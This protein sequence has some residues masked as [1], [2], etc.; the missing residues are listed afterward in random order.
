MAP[1]SKTPEGELTAPELRKLIRAHNILS[2]ITIPKGSDREGLIKLIE[3]SG[4]K[5]NHAKKRLDAQVKRGKQITLKK[6]EELTKPK[7]V[8]DAVKKQRAEKKKEQEEQKEKDIKIAKKEAVQE[9]KTKKKEA[10]KLKSIPPRKILKKENLSNTIKESMGETAFIKQQKKL[11]LEKQKETRSALLKQNVKVDKTT[12]RGKPVKKVEPVKKEETGIRLITDGKVDIRV[13]NVE[14]ILDYIDKTFDSKLP[15][16]AQVKKLDKLFT[17]T[18]ENPKYVT[19]MNISANRGAYPSTY[20]EGN[21][22]IEPFYM[23]SGSNEVPANKIPFKWIKFKGV[24][25]TKVKK[26]KVEP[27]K[28]KGRMSVLMGKLKFKDLSEALKTINEKKY[29]EQYKKRKP[30]HEEREKIT[31]EIRSGKF[32]LKQ[33]GDLMKKVKTITKKID[34]IDDDIRKA[35][36]KPITEEEKELLKL[37]YEDLMKMD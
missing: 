19:G 32:S 34:I 8:S 9:F 20:D 23:N 29:P 14:D 24:K 36:P 17:L 25:K 37:I 33:K 35:E 28:E 22:Y 10:Q 15:S 30:L 5:V 21:I 11:Q 27:I 13:K 1:K 12:R 16:D 2:K 3:G 6:A 18:D 7:P 4:Y 26:K 31:K